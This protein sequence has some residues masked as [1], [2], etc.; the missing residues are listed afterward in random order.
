MHSDKTFTITIF[1]LL[2]STSLYCQTEDSLKVFHFDGFKWSI[3]I[4][5]NFHNFHPIEW[6]EK[7]SKGAKAIGEVIGEE[8]EL[9]TDMVFIYKSG[10][11]NY[12][13]CLLQHYEEDEDYEQINQ[14]IHQVILATFKQNV[15]GAKIESSSSVEKISGL[16]FHAFKIKV[17]NPNG[18]VFHTIMYSRLFGQ[19]EFAMNIMYLDEGKGAEMLNAW[20]NSSFELFE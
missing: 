5:E 11:F 4:P 10:D 17:N 18:I 8:V 2:F 13:E 20:N 19:K 6:S 3:A 7:Q 14:E 1:L 9:N 12:F 15:P 16:E